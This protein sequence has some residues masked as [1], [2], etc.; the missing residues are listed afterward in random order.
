[1]QSF[2]ADDIQVEPFDGSFRARIFTRGH[3]VCEIIFKRECGLKADRA[4]IVS[5]E[6]S[7]ERP[8]N[9]VAYRAP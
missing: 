1:M 2:I 9:L 6:E 5:L 4:F 8:V 3:E 7:E